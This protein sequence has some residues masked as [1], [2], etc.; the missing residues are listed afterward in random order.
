L[1]ARAKPTA[2]ELGWLMVPVVKV[3]GMDH[4]VLT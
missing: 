3:L 4:S 2:P 1:S